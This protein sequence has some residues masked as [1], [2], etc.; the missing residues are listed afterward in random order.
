MKMEV[1]P[2][3]P[4]PSPKSR[5][6][7]PT[8]LRS[9]CHRLLKP[10]TPASQPTKQ[11]LTKEPCLHRLAEYRCCSC[12]VLTTPL[13]P[14]RIRSWILPGCKHRPEQILPPRQL[15]TKASLSMINKPLT[16]TPPRT[17][18]IGVAVIAGWTCGDSGRSFALTVSGASQSAVNESFFGLVRALN[19]ERSNNA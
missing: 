16:Q 12:G 17:A 3:P 19:A 10:P 15:A 1:F 18:T 9:R 8:G 6:T 4:P 14:D 7:E 5:K 11:R 2:S 13:T